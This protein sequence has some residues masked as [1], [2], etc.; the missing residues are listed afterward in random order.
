MRFT[1]LEVCSLRFSNSCDL[2]VNTPRI[3]SDLVTIPTRIPLSRTRTLD[4]PFSIIFLAASLTGAV[5][6]TVTRSVC[7]IS[8]I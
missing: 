7:I 6:F 2:F 3:K 1:I 4:E 5:A 8:S